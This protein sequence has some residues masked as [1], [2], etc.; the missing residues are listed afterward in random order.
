[1]LRIH[2]RLWTELDFKIASSIY[3]PIQ[4]EIIQIQNS[5]INKFSSLTNAIY[6]L[7][8]TGTG[9]VQSDANVEENVNQGP[10]GDV[11][12]DV[13]RRRR[14]GRRP[15]AAGTESFFQNASSSVEIGDVSEVAAPQVD[16]ATG[17]AIERRRDAG[18][19]VKIVIVEIAVGAVGDGR[20][21][22]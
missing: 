2:L 15:G 18:D 21:V 20:Q 16:G 3:F 8:T 11:T 10:A 9:N 6:K 22:G 7:I 1:M 14:N 19:R 5:Q 17:G 4:I 13:R 12:A